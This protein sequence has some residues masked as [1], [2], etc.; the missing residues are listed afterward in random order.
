MVGEAIGSGAVGRPVRIANCSG[1][2]G[3]RVAA[4]GEMVDG[5]PIDYLTGDWL[6]ELTMLIL[7][8]TRAKR[9]GG[10]FARTFV[11]QMEEV[12]GRCLERGIKVVANAGGLDPAGCAEAVQEVADRLGLA[13][14]IGVVTGDDL[15]GRL[16]ELAAAGHLLEHLETGEPLGSRRDDAVTANA[17]LGCWGIVEAL[18]AGAD[19]VITGRVTD[20]AVVMGPA[21]HEHGWK[22]DDWDALA[23]ACVA[24]HV[25][26]C[27]AQATGGNYSFFTEVPD[28][29]HAGFPLA[30]VAADGSSVITKH[31]G[32]GGRVDIGTV[33]S[34]LLYEIGSPRYLNPDVVAR[35]DTITLRDDGPDRVAI[36]A[37][38]GEPAPEMLKV[39]VNYLGGYRNSFTFCLTGLDIEAKAALLEEQIWGHVPGGRDAFAFARAQLVRTDHD[40]PA[41]NEAATALLRVTVKDPDERLVGRAFSNV[42]IELALASIPGFYGLGGPGTASPYGVFWP[43]AVPADLCPQT[44]TVG[45]RVTVVDGRPAGPGGASTGRRTGAGIGSRR[46]RGADRSS[47]D[48]EGG[49]RPLRRQGRHGQPRGLRP[50]G[51]GLRLAFLLPDRGAAPGADAGRDRRPGGPAP[52]PPQPPRAELRHRRPAGGGCGRQQPDGRPGQEP[53]RV[54]AGQGGGGAGLAA[55]RRAVTGNLFSTISAAAPDPST[56]LAEL[57]DGSSTTYAEA[58]ALAARFA[59]ALEDLGVEPGDRVAVQVEKSWPAIVLY[60][61]CLRAGAVYLPLNPAYTA[62]EVEHFLRDAEPKV[63]VCDSER[64]DGLASLAQATGVAHVETMGADGRGSL[65]D[66]ALG[67]PAERADAVRAGS[68]LAAILYTSGTTGRSKGAMLTHDNLRSNAQALVECWRFTADDVLVHALPIFHTHGLFVATNV[69][70]LSGGSMIFQPGFDAAAVLAALGR[71]TA[72][73]GVPTF[74]TRLLQLPGLTREAVAGVRLFVSGSAPL[75]AETH[76]AW[77]ERTGHAILERYGMTETNMNTSNPYDGE[78]RP[79]TVGFPLPGVELRVVDPESGRPV[80]T[81][82]VGGLEVKGPNVFC[83]YWRQPERTAEELRAD[84]FFIT[85]DLAAVDGDGYVRIV[86]RAK[87]LVI[88]GGLNVYPKEVEEAIDELPGVA[89]SAVFGVPHPDFGEAVVAAVVP[90][91][92]AVVQEAVGARRAR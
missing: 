11:T 91:S 54:P 13:P 10:G 72:L 33:T 7:A 12:M 30:E 3:D 90:A 92:G 70:L 80:A 42:A 35:F 60:L 29:R 83:G 52:R 34:Q 58:F 20:A 45:D 64:F 89:E 88:S 76:A 56:V 75:L 53:R 46:A 68:D 81:D 55:R 47:A 18:E 40:D 9:P 17:Y 22:P 8:R 71:A 24:G 39:G 51:R 28:L 87:D 37:V 21:A 86:G 15:M 48:R 19:I 5:G 43:A 6:A 14:R 61:G 41:T 31:P 78:R 49:R 50:L 26:E 32:S 79:G 57:P 82:E 62:A 16:D 4:A 36:G 25:I 73:M 63:L 77:S 84:G 23:G 38:R 85:G 66:H 27:G 44:V 74:Y 67:Q 2:Y 1:F 65:L 69:V 59:N